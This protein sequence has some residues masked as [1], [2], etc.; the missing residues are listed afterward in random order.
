MTRVPPFT[1][2]PKSPA[3]PELVHSWS[4][5]DLGR[6]LQ[7]LLRSAGLGVENLP[8]HHP[9]RQPGGDDI[10][11]CLTRAADAAGLEL[12]PI[13]IDRGGSRPELPAAGPM[14]IGPDPGAPRHWWLV[15]AGGRRPVVWSPV[16]G[17]TSLEPGRGPD[18][19]L[20]GL[21]ADGDRHLDQVR[22]L[23]G[24]E[25]GRKAVHKGLAVLRSDA[26]PRA[27]GW[28]FEAGP[29]SGWIR[30]L[31][32]SARRIFSGTA[33]WVTVQL[34][35]YFCWWAVWWEMS[36]GAHGRVPGF[37][38]SATLLL[39]LA[40]LVALHSLSTLWLGQVSLGWAAKLK[41]LWMAG[42]LQP[43]EGSNRDG[44][45]DALA[46]LFDSETMES[47]LRDTGPAAFATLVELGP[48]LILL[49]H[50][51]LG[52]P[53]TTMALLSLA[54][55]I[56]LALRS[57]R[58]LDAVTAV[59][60]R[61]TREII[62]K[63]AGHETRRVQEPPCKRHVDETPWLADLQHTA[64]RHGIHRVELEALP[65]L[66][67]TLGLV[68]VTFGAAGA[69]FGETAVAIAGILLVEQV[70]GGLAD[71]ALSTASAAVG[72][73]SVSPLVDAATRA[74]PTKTSAGPDAVESAPSEAPLASLPLVAGDDL[75]CRPPKARK[76]IFEHLSL[77]VHS[78]DHILLEGP[79][80]G[81]KS[82]LARLL[83][84]LQEADDG[85]IYVAGWAQDPGLHEEWRRR[86]V[87]VPQ[88]HDNYVFTQSL[89]FNLLM[90]RSWP[91]TEQD[92]VDAYELCRELGLG[93]LIDRMPAG[94]GQIVGE[95]GWRLS[96]GEQSRVFLARALLQGPDLLILDESFGA[97]DPE[98]FQACLSCAERR[99]KTLMVIAHP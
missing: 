93:D 83:V 87:L 13:T 43:D 15:I 4:E 29:R 92:V 45:G 41:T 89:A 90:G 67:R 91:P 61:S 53:L 42:I 96:H 5:T 62:E 64:T 37:A 85:T 94:M 23:L 63:V 54:L 34:A 8:L 32:G 95:N 44:E 69:D 68:V 60:R 20:E 46:R 55:L 30:F 79:S 39:L 73:R 14:I 6:G 57:Y 86:A 9:L 22:N 2:L 99:A 59:R 38:G 77:A 74:R 80:G 33:A 82:T 11:R 17:R 36:T 27:V 51:T 71:A 26:E 70:L 84:G 75:R 81:G 52:G 28:A 10:G 56:F 12:R 47:L 24:P 58:S 19:C 50:G 35:H 65:R 78:G 31:G 97:L 21:P 40:T 76:P 98:T 18:R 48:A 66:W 25:A 3:R 72:H 7:G 16:T 1:G 88:F 49:Y